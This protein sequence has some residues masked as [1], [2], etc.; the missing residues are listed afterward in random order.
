MQKIGFSRH[1]AESIREIVFGL[2]DSLVSTMGTLTGIAIGTHSTFV[3]ILSGL[4]LLATEGTSM[5][6][7]SYLSSKSALET[8]QNLHSGGHVTVAQKIKSVHAAAVMGISYFFGGFVPLAPYFF[9]STT[10]AVFLSIFLTTVSLFLVGVWSS[11]FTK[12]PALRSGFEM[13]VISCIAALI[14][15]VIARVVSQYLPME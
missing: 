2:E 13:L 12:R 5:A 9:L 1:I 8:E 10:P 3:V 4:V 6:A 7:G 14:G 15:Y 11:R